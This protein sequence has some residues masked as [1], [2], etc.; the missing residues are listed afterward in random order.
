MNK[1]G[2]SQ[3]KNYNIEIHIMSAIMLKR[4]LHA[5]NN[6]QV[7]RQLHDGISIINVSLVL[8]MQYSFH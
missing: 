3:Y 8:I 6:V 2:N 7:L 4:W 5:D 1:A